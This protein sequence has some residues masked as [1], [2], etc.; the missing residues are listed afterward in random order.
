VA[1]GLSIRYLV[2]PPVERY[3]TERQLYV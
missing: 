1:E 2:P 3:I